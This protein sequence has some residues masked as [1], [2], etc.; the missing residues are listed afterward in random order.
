ML[1][2]TVKCVVLY[3]MLQAYLYSDCQNIV[4]VEMDPSFCKLQQQIILDYEFADRVKV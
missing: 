3:V 4:G 2:M 1:V